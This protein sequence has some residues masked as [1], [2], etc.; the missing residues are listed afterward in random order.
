MTYLDLL[1]GLIVE[2]ICYLEELVHH[3]LLQFGSNLFRTFFGYLKTK[4][5][6]MINTAPITDI[7]VIN[8]YTRKYIRS[9]QRN[10]RKS[11]K[12]NPGQKYKFSNKTKGFMHNQH[13]KLLRMLG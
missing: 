2:P 10:E 5:I 1:G 4:H 8:I 12:E 9:D 3:L 13:K 6:R 7:T 11:I